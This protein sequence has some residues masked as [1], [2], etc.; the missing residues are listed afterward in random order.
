MR[1][2][3]AFYGALPFSVYLILAM[4]GWLNDDGG[5]GWPVPTFV[6]PVE[7]ADMCVFVVSTVTTSLLIF[8]A[9]LWNLWCLAAF[10][11]CL[12]T[13]FLFVPVVNALTNTGNDN[14]DSELV[15]FLVFIWALII[16]FLTEY[17]ASPVRQTYVFMLWCM[18]DNE[19][20]NNDVDD[21]S[22]QNTVTS[23]FNE[24][25]SEGKV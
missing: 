6:A 23:K 5:S 1:I 10:G 24:N 25:E 14:T 9:L 13:F 12:S 21:S 3:L 18:E 17:W 20:N 4:S 16:L 22:D 19:E 2:A 11:C 8:S 7:F 15:Q